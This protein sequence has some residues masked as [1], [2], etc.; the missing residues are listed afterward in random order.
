MGFKI[1]CAA[2]VVEMKTEII[3]LKQIRGEEKNKY[4]N[5]DKIS[6]LYLNA[7][8]VIN[9]RDEL[10]LYIIENKPSIIGVKESWANCDIADSELNLEGYELFSK[11]KN[12]MI[13]KWWCSDLRE[14]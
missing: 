3:I 6:C 9:K 4:S 13:K 2:R 5:I 7:R 1:D 11:M 14:K 8:S 12:E 10:E